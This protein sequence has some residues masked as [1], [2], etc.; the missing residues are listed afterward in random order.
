M[1]FGSNP[2][3][4]QV[5]ALTDVGWSIVRWETFPTRHE[6]DA[7]F[8]ALCSGLREGHFGI[9]YKEFPRFAFIQ[10]RSRELVLLRVYRVYHDAHND[11]FM[12]WTHRENLIPPHLRGDS[13]DEDDRLFWRIY[14]E[15]ASA[16]AEAR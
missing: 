2:Y 16:E 3:L 14:V 11:Y 12:L 5:E 6:R 9:Y 15:N 10:Q 4:V 7:R 13:T 1:C 8:E